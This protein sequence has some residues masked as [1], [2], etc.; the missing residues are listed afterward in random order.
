MAAV[1]PLVVAV[2]CKNFVMIGKPETYLNFLSFMLESPLCG[3]KFSFLGFNSQNFGE[4]R[5]DPPKA[6]PYA[7]WRILSRLWCRSIG[8]PCSS[9]VYTQAFPIGENLGNFRGP[10]L[11]Y[12]M[13]QENPSHGRENGDVF[14]DRNSA[15]HFWF[16]SSYV[17][18]SPKC[19][20]TVPRLRHFKGRTVRVQAKDTNMPTVVFGS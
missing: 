8:A 10:Q 9:I 6:H 17:K 5:S 13:S 11:P 18:L 3:P 7:E 2:S 20:S 1:R 19:S 16:T 4:H 14:F 15:A 12:Q